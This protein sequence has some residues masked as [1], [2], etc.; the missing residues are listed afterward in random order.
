MVLAPLGV[1][2]A[3]DVEQ[4]GGVKLSSGRARGNVNRD[5]SALYM[6]GMSRLRYFGNSASLPSS[7]RNEVN[8]V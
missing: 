8:I 3:D 6:D 5:S 1:R 7:R 4:E 2:G